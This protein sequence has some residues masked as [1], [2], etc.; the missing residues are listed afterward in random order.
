MIVKICIAFMYTYLSF[1]CIACHGDEEL[2][3]C[4][5]ALTRIAEASALHTQSQI[6]VFSLEPSGPTVC[7][8]NDLQSPSRLAK[9]LQ[10]KY[11][12]EVA[13]I[14]MSD[15]DL[16]NEL[17]QLA[18]APG[19]SFAS[20]YLALLA[21]SQKS[22]ELARPYLLKWMSS[23]E[24]PFIFAAW[25]L[26]AKNST[27]DGSV[28][29]P[30]TAI[31]DNALTPV[32]ECL[33]GDR[34][35]ADWFQA[36]WNYGRE[37]APA[38]L[39]ST[40]AA[41]FDDKVSE[42]KALSID[43]NE[44]LKQTDLTYREFVETREILE[45]Q[46]EVLHWIISSI[47]WLSI[48]INSDETEE[49]VM[50]ACNCI[51]G[52][53]PLDFL[54]LLSR[55]D[56]PVALAFLESEFFESSDPKYRYSIVKCLSHSSSPERIPYIER[57][58]ADCERPI[59]NSSSI[60]ESPSYP[61]S[62]SPPLM[63]ALERFHSNA[64]EEILLN[65]AENS[66]EPEMRLESITQLQFHNPEI[67]VDRLLQL[68]E[69]LPRTLRRPNSRGPTSWSNAIKYEIIL[70]LKDCQNEEIDNFFFK[71][72]K[73]EADLIDDLSFNYDVALLEAMNARDNSCYPA[74]DDLIE[75]KKTGLWMP[76]FITSNV[77][78]QVAPRRL[79]EEKSDELT[80]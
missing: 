54:T 50:D 31:I 33:E 70:R 61:R 46:L 34:E 29:L 11:R 49:Y 37:I 38:M 68:Y 4:R 15:I 72:G 23:E 73:D 42:L 13:V 80:D 41:L 52:P 71:W 53:L 43:Y 60:E 27:L 67:V 25:D 3:I 9:M 77:P 79:G 28:L 20:R 7:S 57:C 21:L 12:D 59:Q 8:D 65:I 74:L 35:H 32:F 2:H 55:Y 1:T 10:F 26:A 39:F 63:I 62:L 56:E 48:E 5:E 14:V 75:A 36:M 30:E 16:S 17:I 22:P 44:L 51:E 19:A 78:I 69:T 45:N 64:P 58:L 47:A 76:D 40:I 18:D 24:S 66:D 6:N